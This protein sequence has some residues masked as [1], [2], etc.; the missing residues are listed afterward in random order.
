[1]IDRESVAPEEILLG[2]ADKISLRELYAMVALHGVLSRREVWVKNAVEIAI[3][4]ADEMVEKL[5]KKE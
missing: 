5:N 4:L 2:K 1:M 3:L